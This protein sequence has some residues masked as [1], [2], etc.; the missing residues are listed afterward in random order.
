MNIKNGIC[1]L[2]LTTSLITGGCESNRHPE[3]NGFNGKIGEAVVEFKTREGFWIDENTLTAKFSDGTTITYIDYPKN[4]QP[5]E[6]KIDRVIITKNDITTKYSVHSSN[7]SIQE[8]I[9]IA[10]NNFDEYLKKII[11]IQTSAL[12]KK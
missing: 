3:Y 10:Q 12:Y 11:E 4:N 1:G 5:D 6:L 9:K 7:P 8:K 2:I